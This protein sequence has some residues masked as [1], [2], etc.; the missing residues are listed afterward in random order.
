MPLHHAVTCTTD[1]CRALYLAA[2]RLGRDAALHA[3][4]RAG[5]A[6]STGGLSTRCPACHRAGLPVLERGDCP[7]CGGALGPSRSG[8]RC[9]YCGH[10]LPP[11]PVELDDEAPEDPTDD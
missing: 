2:P 4:Q 7:V 9:H 11:P 3:A 8:D 5:W 1:G 10:L 6:V